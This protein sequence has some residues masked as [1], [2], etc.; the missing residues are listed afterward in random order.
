MK[1]IQLTI[2]TIL[3]FCLNALLGCKDKNDNA[4]DVSHISVALEP[5]NFYKDFAA[6]DT[7]NLSKGL[8]ELSAQYGE[9]LH[10]YLDTLAVGLSQNA[11][12]TNNLESVHIFLTHKDYKGLIDT[13]N[14]AFKQT[15][16]ITLQIKSMLQYTKHYIPEIILPTKVYYFVSGLNNYT[17]VTWG[18]DALCVGLDYFLG[19][20]FM[21]YIAV[22]NPEYTTIRFTK[23]NIPVWAARVIYQNH[24]TP[25]IPEGKTLLE[26]MIAQ[27]KEM[28][29]TEKVLPKVADSLY[30]GFT[31]AQYKWCIENEAQ[32]YS[33]FQQHELLFDKQL[34]KVMRY[35]MDGPFATGMPPESPGN[36]GTF[37]GY[38]IVKSFAENNN[39]DLNEVLN[40]TDAQYIL[41]KAKYKP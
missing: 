15:E 21:P 23:E 14:I 39:L 25:L 10:F 1:K 11:N 7:A 36:V 18:D 9:F 26:M 34:Q 16:D 12:Y 29:F 24:F 3:L 20:N 17:A 6:L 22:G 28:Y 8:D 31:N 13:V 19:R 30:F 37:I 33:Y 32:I 4:P 40:I 35:V 41:S 2:L 5:I 27:G 38:R